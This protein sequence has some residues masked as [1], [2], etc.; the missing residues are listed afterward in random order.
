MGG[1]KIFNRGEDMKP[2]SPKV[3]IRPPTTPPPEEWKGG[4]IEMGIDPE[5]KK[6]FD[7]EM[8]IDPEG[9]KGREGKRY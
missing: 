7:I 9:K 8:G 6:E 2:Q 3:N 4:D 1:G 5:G